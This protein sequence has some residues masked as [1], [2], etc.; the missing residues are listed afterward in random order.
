MAAAANGDGPITV[1]FILS[2]RR[3]GSTWLNN[4]LGS[5]SWATSLGEY[6]R[7][8]FDRAHVACRLCEADGLDRCTVLHG[9]EHVPRGEAF[10]FA[11]A[12]TGHRVLVDAS[13]RLDWS[14]DFIGRPDL[15]VRLL[16]LVRHPCGYVESE[17]RR[18]PEALPDALVDEWDRTN[19]D[20]ARFIESS[21]RLTLSASYEALAAEPGR[22]FPP[23]CEW[24][25]GAYEPRALAYWASPNHGLGANGASSLYLRGRPN[26]QYI[27]GDDAYYD[28]LFDARRTGVDERWRERLPPEFCRRV[29][30]SPRVSQIMHRLGVPDWVAH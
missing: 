2:T 25:G 24:L 3:A 21:G 8:F 19:R 27:T 9:I 13:K 17:M 26:K 14:A 20:I 5:H 16:H 18:S 29:V 4:V 7:P 23:I 28:A 15:D 22:Y 12:R 30:A 10:H 11:A 1:V 6:C